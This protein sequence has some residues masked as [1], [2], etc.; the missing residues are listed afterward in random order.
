LL[1]S[2]HIVEAMVKDP[3][4]CTDDEI[5]TI[6]KYGYFRELPIVNAYVK[7]TYQG[8]KQSSVN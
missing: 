6:A 8:S 4:Y 3:Q 1:S 2:T 5:K 7:E